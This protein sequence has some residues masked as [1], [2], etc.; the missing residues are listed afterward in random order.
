VDNR[1]LYVVVAAVGFAFLLSLYRRREHYAYKFKL[2]L[3]MELAYG[4]AVF[5]AVQLGR[6]QLE[7]ILWGVVA[8]FVVFMKTKPRG[9][10]I[11]ASVRRRRKAEYELRT[12]KK[13]NPRKIE[14]DHDVPHARGGGS[15]EDN[16][17]VVEKRKN[18]SKGA[19]SP[20]WDLLGR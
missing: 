6:Q 12:G 11:S 4:V 13:F 5:I 9:R 19:K 16:I 8:G 18:R 1:I 7:P 2:I 10:Y 20:W 15:T 17:R 3:R 14:Y